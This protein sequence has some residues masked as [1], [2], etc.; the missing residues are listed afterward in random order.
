LKLLM[1]IVR[2]ATEIIF[3]DGSY[4]IEWRQLMPNSYFPISAFSAPIKYSSPASDSEL[5]SN[6]KSKSV[7]GEKP[8]VLDQYFEQ[9]IYYSNINIILS[10]VSE[11]GELRPQDNK[12]EKAKTEEKKEA[13]VVVIKQ[14]RKNAKSH[15][16]S[17]VHSPKILTI[18]NKR[19]N[20]DNN[21]NDNND[22]KEEHIK[23]VSTIETIFTNGKRVKRSSDSKREKQNIQ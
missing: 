9:S 14:E 12:Q 3:T 16:T 22:I 4:C 10:T 18:G 5:F 2:E 23:R 21:N 13:V 1:F 6:I 7:E 20:G 19:K 15:F 17:H 11:P 8:K